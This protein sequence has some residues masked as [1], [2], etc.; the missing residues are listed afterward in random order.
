MPYNALIDLPEPVKKYL[1]TKALIIWMDAFNKAYWELMYPEPRC[2]AYAWQ[3][4][5]NQGYKKDPNTG[6]WKK[7]KKVKVR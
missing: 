3:A 4:V 7:V 5:K 2:F 6:M 1:P